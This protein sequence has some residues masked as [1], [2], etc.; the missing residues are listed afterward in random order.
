MSDVPKARTLRAMRKMAVLASYQQFGEM[1]FGKALRKKLKK[2]FKTHA[3][4]LV[5]YTACWADRKYKNA[6]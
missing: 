1:M 2:H 5:R 4:L 6:P 3:D